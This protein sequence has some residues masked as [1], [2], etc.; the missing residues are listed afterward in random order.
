[1]PAQ[2]GIQSL[3]DGVS[4]CYRRNLDSGFRRNDARQVDSQ[5]IDFRTP[6]LGA[7]LFNLAGDRQLQSVFLYGALNCE[8]FP[9][10]NCAQDGSTDQDL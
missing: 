5:S 4:L 6:W 2:A 8:I 9:K 7:V 1:M 3:S 10:M